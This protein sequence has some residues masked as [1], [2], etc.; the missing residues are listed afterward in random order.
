MTRL[1]P[2]HLLLVGALVGGRVNGILF[3][4]GAHLGNWNDRRFGH[5]M[6]KDAKRIWIVLDRISSWL[7]I[8]GDR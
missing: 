8:R 3:R 2:R 7:Y 1:N 6:R 5:D 4:I